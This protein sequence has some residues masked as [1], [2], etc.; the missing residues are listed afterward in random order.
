MPRLA[1]IVKGYNPG[2]VLPEVASARLP[3][4]SVVVEPDIEPGVKV[5]V[6]PPGVEPVYARLIGE[7]HEPGLPLKLKSSE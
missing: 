2:T 7:L 5:V 1:V 3:V 6:V 4:P